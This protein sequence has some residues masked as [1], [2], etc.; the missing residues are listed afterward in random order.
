MNTNTIQGF[1][2]SPQQR[3]V[4]ALQGGK[5]HTPFRAQ[6]TVQVEGHLDL[7]SLSTALEGVALKHEILRTRYE[8]F[9]GMTWPLQV[10]EQTAAVSIALYDLTALSSTAQDEEV[11]RL[12]REMSQEPFAFRQGGLFRCRVVRLSEDT[13]RLLLSLPALNADVKTLEILVREIALRWTPGADAQPVIPA[14]AQYAD[15]S[16]WLNELAETENRSVVFLS[17]DPD[18]FLRFKLPFEKESAASKEFA[19]Q[20]VCAPIPFDTM[21]RL[22]SQAKR[23]EVSVSSCF[24][25]CWQI[26]LSRLAGEA[27]ILVGTLSRCRNHEDT[28]GAMGLFARY[29]P[30]R[31]RVEETGPFWQLLQEVDRCSKHL[32]EQAEYFKW[33]GLDKPSARPALYPFCYQFEQAPVVH[34]VAK[35][36]F[37]VLRQQALL[38]RFKVQL[39][40]LDSGSSSLEFQYDSNLYSEGEI[41]RLAAE[42]LTLLTSSALGPES[43]IGLLNHVSDEERRQ[44]LIEFNDT[45]RDYARDGRIHEL[46]EQH[47]KLHPDRIAVVYEHQQITY[48]ELNV[49]AN[50]LGHYLRRCGVG[51]EVLV[52]ICLERSIEMVVGILGTL[53]AGGAW[54]PLDPLFPKER[55]ALMLDD[56]NVGVVISHSRLLQQLPQNGPRVLQLDRGWPE[57]SEEAVETPSGEVAPENLAYVIYTSGS[58]GQP[59]GVAICHGNVS[60]YVLAMAEALNLRDDDRYLHTASMS[61]SS[62]VRQLMVPLSLGATVVV[63]SVNEIHD[64]I[65][66][67]ENIKTNGVRVIDIVPTHWRSCVEALAQMEESTR[68]NLL[69][70]RLRLV[71]SASEPLHAD[72]PQAWRDDLRHNA[73]LIN[74]FGQ[75]ETTGIVSLRPI[76]EDLGGGGNIVSIGKPIPNMQIYVLNSL[77]QPVSIGV[78]GEVFI[79]GAD[80]GRGYVNLP[81]LT[82]ERFVPNPFSHKP[83]GRLYRTGDLARH[84][85]D[86]NLEFL[87]RVD[88]QIK[89]RGFRIEPA[90]IEAF[91]GKH[92][93]VRRAVIVRETG[94]AGDAS[95][96][97]YAVLVEKDGA[98]VNELRTH[99]RQRLPEYM[100]PARFVTLESLPLTPT[101]KIDRRALAAA[102]S[103]ESRPGTGATPPRNETERQLVSIWAEVLCVQN[104]G[105][106]QDFFALGGQSLLA[107][108]LL[109]RAQ[110]VFEVNLSWQ[111]FF[112]APTILGM[113][114][115]I[116][117]LR[118]IQP[119]VASTSAVLTLSREEGEL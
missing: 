63:A 78:P 62:S 90:E 42:F 24:L 81:D 12:F 95:L 15:L 82:A 53:K 61:F 118:S 55:L 101:G 83:G 98:S 97:A 80:L 49:R 96:V 5:A 72:L 34:T 33:D 70:N 105:I 100:V 60:H 2:L 116:E 28:A 56:A 50:R 22:R 31:L 115:S 40:V 27:E 103:Q 10:I 44:V 65:K 64:P 68:S 48:R 51:P 36:S 17:L 35:T 9:E 20:A 7:E 69:D 84:L 58:T 26:L 18:D 99:L 45:G 112:A 73:V 77:S 85:P 16:E 11:E 23:F 111:G 87:G 109:L 3:R 93:A 66:L 29:L 110:E 46:F 41:R 47:A 88:D 74:M 119:S 91:L 75:T 89:I 14:E 92:P 1:R 79:G 114:H 108:R 8:Y 54:L 117:N 67:F 39:C 6:C 32:A 57:I 104:P 59:K 43:K 19:P 38:D 21:D 71:V 102:G 94:R 37:T 113:G 107:T 25:T 52:G 4:W 86:G 13:H 76:P 30:M 106:D